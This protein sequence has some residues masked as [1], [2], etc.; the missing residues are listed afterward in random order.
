MA[1]VQFAPPLQR[2]TSP[3]RVASAPPP[4]PPSAD[5]GNPHSSRSKRQLPSR[6]AASVTAAVRS[7]PSIR[8]TS[9]PGPR[10]QEIL[11]PNKSEDRPTSS[12]S[13]RRRR[14][15]R[16]K[17]LDLGCCSSGWSAALPTSFATRRPSE[18]LVRSVVDSASR[19]AIRA[20]Q[21]HQRRV[22]GHPLGRP[23]RR[24]Q[25]RHDQGA[26]GLRCRAWSEHDETQVAAVFTSTQ[27]IRTAESVFRPGQ[28]PGSGVV[29]PVCPS[30]R[31][32]TTLPSSSRWSTTSSTSRCETPWSRP[33]G[34]RRGRRRQDQHPH[35]RA[36]P[37]KGPLGRTGNLGPESPGCSMSPTPATLTV[38]GEL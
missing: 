2:L 20:T 36:R 5:A 4:P 35:V 33:R 11:M 6:P 17:K 29:S 7:R 15:S 37:G 23:E 14:R 19:H 12:R 3:P 22:L 18:V 16:G 27:E 8:D 9:G 10:L 32:P 38:D 13:G 30:H 28:A 26:A 21:P 34:R 1:D 31:A 25:Q 24:T